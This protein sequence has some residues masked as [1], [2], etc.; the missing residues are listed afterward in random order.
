MYGSIYGMR[1][2]ILVLAIT[3]V[4]SLKMSYS[5]FAQKTAAGWMYN[6]AFDGNTYDIGPN[7]MHGQMVGGVS[8]TTDRFGR[9]GKH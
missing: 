9:E 2:V 8:A 4:I 3:S 6:Y 7:R 5:S 1:N